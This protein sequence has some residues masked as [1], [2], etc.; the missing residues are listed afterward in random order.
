MCY[1]AGPFIAKVSCSPSKAS[2]CLRIPHSLAC[3]YK[4][5]M[6]VTDT[7]AYIN[8]KLITAIKS[9]IVQAPRLQTLRFTQVRKKAFT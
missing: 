7:P 5:R 6:E 3:K 2:L 8:L 9:D 1:S 4:T